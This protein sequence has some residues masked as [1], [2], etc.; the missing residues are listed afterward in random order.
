MY[1]YVGRTNKSLLS[2]IEISLAVACCLGSFAAAAENQNF[3][4][5]WM[6]QAEVPGEN[7]I[8]L[9]ELQQQGEQWLAYMET[10]PAR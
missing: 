4:G 5:N 10:G 2:I 8:G 6:I 7:L 3:A 1:G 9:L